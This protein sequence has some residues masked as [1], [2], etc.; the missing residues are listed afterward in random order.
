MTDL[1]RPQ[2]GIELAALETSARGALPGSVPSGSSR[3]PA[4]R[5]GGIFAGGTEG[6]ER[7]T[8]QAGALLFVGL[9]VLGVTIVR[10]GQLTWLHLFLGLL[11]LG[12]VALKLSATG[13]R[14]LRYYS[15]DREYGRKGPP[16]LPLRVLA[17][18]VVA[19]TLGVFATGVVL[20]AV[21]PNRRDPWMLLH[22]ASF[23]VWVGATALHVL[24]HLPEMRRGLLAQGSTRA[25]VF[26][27]AGAGLERERPSR[28]SIAGYRL[29][30]R[31]AGG[32]AR[33][34]SLALALGA[35][36]ILALA[37]TGH[38]DPWLHYRSHD[39]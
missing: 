14:F 2:Q 23:I 18:V 10:I 4:R 5:R 37:L 25:E 20:L 32:P 30:A 21:G 34:A 12:P 36:L 22:K 17:P 19:S 8:V 28:I 27:A 29:A 35:G 13:Y 38:F 11:L 7:L 39:R 15:G 26:A 24:G 9:A 33:G 1:R 16:F 3:A 6:N 31:F